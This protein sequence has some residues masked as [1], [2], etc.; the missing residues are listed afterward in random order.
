ML[1]YLLS[2][3]LVLYLFTD[4]CTCTFWIDLS[5]ASCFILSSLSITKFSN[6]L[7]D[8]HDCLIGRGTYSSSME[9]QLLGQVSAKDVYL[10]PQQRRSM[11]LQVR[12]RRKL[13]GSEISSTTSGV[14]NINPLLFCATIRVRYAWCAIPNFTSVPSTLM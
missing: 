4:L 14:V 13:L 5:I 8:P 1:L 9:D 10:C 7:Q 2:T 3:I 11:L 6:L 12:R